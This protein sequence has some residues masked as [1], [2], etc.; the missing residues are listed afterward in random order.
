[1]LVA[2]DADPSR[3]QADTGSRV[4]IVIG[5]A[6]YAAGGLPNPVNDARAMT[7]VLRELSFDVLLLENVDSRSMETMMKVLPRRFADASV[8]LFYY[9][10]HGVQYEGE[11]FLLPVDIRLEDPEDLR[12][13]AV[14][15]RQVLD[16]LDQARVGLRVVVLDAC[17]NNPFGGLRGA[18]GQGLAFVERSSG[19]T[20]IAYAAAAGAIAAD[21]SGPNSPYTG[22]LVSALDRPGGDIYDVFRNVRR[23][24]REATGGRQLPWVSGS[25][26]QRFVFRPLQAKAA[27]PTAAAQRPTIAAVLWDAIADS[28]DP[29]DFETFLAH[30]PDAPAA[31]R[32]L[33]RLEDLRAQ[34]YAA[35]PGFETASGPS[36]ASSGDSSPRGLSRSVTPCD[37]A[38]A[39]PDDPARLAPGVAWGLVNSRE[40]IRACATALAKRD[41]SPRLRFQFGR[42]L[43]IGEKFAAAEAFYR[44]ADEA[45]YSQATVNLG[46]MHRTGRGRGV[47][48]GRA[49][50]LYRRA[51]EAGNLRAR[52]NM[53]RLHELG[54]GVPRSYPEALAWYRLA[55]AMGWTN[56]IDSLGNMYR[57][58]RGVPE[59]PVE[60]ARLYRAAA[61]QDHSNAINNLALMYRD[62]QGV[63]KDLGR[64]VDLL[65]RATDLGNRFAPFHLG[66]MHRRAWGV[67][68]DYRRARALLTLAAE[69]GFHEARLKLG[70]MAAAGDG[71]PANPENAYVQY[72]LAREAKVK[73]AAERL[74]AVAKTLSP[75]AAARA[76]SRAKRWLLQNGG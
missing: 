20:L 22:A 46:Y 38:A 76:E 25:L 44:L 5:N 61:A 2:L 41:D 47:N 49:A 12:F 31:P 37:L 50:E 6:R 65:R 39:D 40:A 16:G 11:N 29:D 8:G 19:E 64:A 17:R 57:A 28:R 70:E 67:E 60:A 75:A 69:R 51:A 52:T 54:Q 18:L 45:G 4:A 10:G 72:R 1:M 55:A 63:E 73:G 59:D 66:R 13:D 34:G 36:D 24:V 7:S 74:A 62:G 35:I 15:L 42:V 9:A 23:Q 14:S 53:G 43:D 68:R 3:G 27:S 56:A 71:A 32:A 58:G 21:G 48:P 33:A 30:F 26:E